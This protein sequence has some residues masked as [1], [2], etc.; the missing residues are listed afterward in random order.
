MAGVT[1]VQLA[2][3]IGSVS[4]D[5]LKEQLRRAGVH[6]INDHDV[7]SDEEKEKLLSLLRQEHGNPTAP[8]TGQKISLKRTSVSTIKVK[9]AS[10]KSSTVNVISK[11]RRVYVKRELVDALQDDELQKPG[12]STEEQPSTDNSTAATATREDI[13]VDA[14]NVVS[15]AETKDAAVT[16]ATKET[17]EVKKGKD[18][19]KQAVPDDSDTKPRDNKARRKGKGKQQD[20]E[21]E[22]V[23]RTKEKSRKLSKAKLLQE[24]S[25]DEED[26]FRVKTRGAKG[27]THK[28]QKKLAEVVNRH[29]FEKPTAPIIYEVKIPETIS[30]AELAQKISV[31]GVEIIKALMKLG[32]MVTINQVIDQDTACIVVEELGHK[33]C[34]IQGTNIEELMPV[35]YQAE[36]VARSPIITV[37]GHVD[38]GKTSLLD[39][40]RRTSVAAGE[41]GG[42]TQHIGAYQVQTSRGL[43]TFLD[44]P[45]HSAFTAMRARGASCTDIVVLVVAAD[46]GVMPQT[47]EAIQHAK[48]AKVPIIV[49]INKIDKPE[50]DLDRVTNELSQYELI[51][52]SWGGDTMFVPISAKKGTGIPELLEAIMLQ[53]EL[54]ELKAYAQGPAQGVV[55]EAYLDRG[56][57]PVA[58]LLIQK[59]Q[60]QKGDMILVGSEYGRVKVM[61]NDNNENIDNAG[62]SVPVEVLGLS[63]VPMAGDKFQVITDERKARDIAALR[64]G[65]SREVRLSRQQSSKLE[66]FM[67]RLQQGELKVLNIVLK[68][69]VQGSIE[70]LV[71]SLEKLSTDDMTVKVIAKGVGGFNESDVNLA[72]ASDA[73]LVGFNVRADAT[74]RKLALNEGVKLNYYSVIYDVIDGI[75]AAIHGKMGPKLVEKIIGVAEVREVFRSSK[76]G[77]IAGCM[78]ID[79]IIKRGNPIRVLR[80]NVVIYTGEL[81]SLRRFKDNVNEV[82]SNMECGIGVKNYN[83]I[84]A[85]DQIEVYEVVEVSVAL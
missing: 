28:K 68:A 74:A 80:N 37:M 23:V 26:E 12:V 75:K 48:A 69:D 19:A 38:H 31:K 51:P 82:R 30:V 47:I 45:G 49:A 64:E 32:T 83:D 29:A 62:P 35:D 17:S 56:R 79:G 34:P 4:L 14:S 84:K 10:G 46:D 85:G 11:K 42:I 41:A 27:E 52:E 61:H 65:K 16:E 7:I 5:K 40:L 81:E 15:P 39:Y 53:A 59:G 33:A 24:I 25:V 9:Q 3:Q 18:N 72:I 60:L 20:S 6:V 76:L 50:A 63:G 22:E 66:G 55:I 21:G 57:G 54:L 77:A 73:L 1:V 2:K 43:A 8:A 71:D 67:H 36:E 44:T 70:A 13:T 78:V 58:T